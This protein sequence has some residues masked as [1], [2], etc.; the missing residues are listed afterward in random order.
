MTEDVVQEIF[1]E[2][3]D[4]APHISSGMLHRREY[5][6]EDNPSNEQQ[7]EADVWA[8][9]F[10]KEQLTEIQ[11]VGQFA[12]EEEHEVTDCGTGVSVTVDPL[13]GSSNIPSNN[14]VGL[15]VGIYDDWLPCKGEKMV[16]SF[17][18]LFGPLTTIIKAE[19]GQVDEYV[20][21]PKDD[22]SV[23]IHSTSKDMSLPDPTV[24]GFGGGDDSWTSN[25]KNFADDIRQ[26]LKLRYG[27]A[28]TGDVNQVIHH[29]GMFAY[30]ELKER[31][32]GKL[33]LMFEANPMAYIFKHLGGD[34]S[35]GR[36]TILQVEPDSLHD[37]T[38]VYLGNRQLIDRLEK[39]LKY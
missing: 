29:G 5:L 1:E 33:R 20:I 26:E 28:L 14:L 4:V 10:V 19:D 37:R 22:D 25:F 39:N 23:E 11:G 31:P 15:I 8:N 32:E 30:P 7:L 12:S 16:A 2:I 27:G 3:A 13:D 6:D 38:P 21:E 36:K 35:N 17:Y 18:V 24:Y 9:E 34:S